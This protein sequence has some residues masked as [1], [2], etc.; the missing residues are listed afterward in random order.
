MISECLQILVENLKYDDLPVNILIGKNL[1]DI[2][3]FYFDDDINEY[4]MTLEGGYDFFETYG[5][6]D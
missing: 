3:D 1:Y 5:E 6:D 4:I 2:K